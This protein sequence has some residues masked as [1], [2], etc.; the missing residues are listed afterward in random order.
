MEK[1][2]KK[3]KNKENPLKILRKKFGKNRKKLLK[4]W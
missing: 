1:N 3:V 4:K 2:V